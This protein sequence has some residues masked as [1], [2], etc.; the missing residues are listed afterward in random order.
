M[1]I[2]LLP[3]AAVRIHSRLLGR[4]VCAGPACPGRRV[5]LRRGR[6]CRIDCR[7]KTEP[8]LRLSVER[9]GTAIQLLRHNQPD[10]PRCRDHRRGT[11]V[12]GSVR[13]DLACRIWGVERNLCGR[14][15]QRVAWS[16][17]GRQRARWRIPS[18][19]FPAAAFGRRPVWYQSGA[20]SDQADAA[21]NDGSFRGI[22]EA[23]TANSPVFARVSGNTGT[24][25]DAIRCACE[26]GSGHCASSNGHA[27][28]ACSPRPRLRSRQRLRLDDRRSHRR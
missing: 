22:Q 10:R 17:P 15:R 18:H 21:I 12:L 19:D 1:S 25:P 6:A 3:G 24:P 27:D 5:D 28:G 8:A 4:G 2:L 20:G 16:W 26:P 11:I 14:Q 7:F 13:T 9:N 23:A